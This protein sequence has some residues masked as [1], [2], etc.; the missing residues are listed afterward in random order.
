MISLLGKFGLRTGQGRHV[1]VHLQLWRRHGSIVSSI[2]VM[3]E[4][5]GVYNKRGHSGHEVV[6]IPLVLP[7][8]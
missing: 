8:R 6:F 2:L 1:D 4:L 5:E 3:H 7:R